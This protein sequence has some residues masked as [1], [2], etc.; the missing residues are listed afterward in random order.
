[1]EI[2]WQEQ[3]RKQ[4][5]HLL[6]SKGTF[7]ATAR[8]GQSQGIAALEPKVGVQRL[9]WGAFGNENNANEPT[10]TTFSG[11]QPCLECV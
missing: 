3:Q 10:Q 6:D 2:L 4:V 1:M 5:R 7:Q 8:S 9:F 11:N